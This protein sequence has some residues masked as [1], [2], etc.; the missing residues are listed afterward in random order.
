M[1]P[2][3]VV[4]STLATLPLLEDGR[5]TLLARVVGNALTTVIVRAE[6]L[7]VYRCTEM[8]SDASRLEPQALLDEIYPAVAYFQDTWEENVQQVR[9]A[10]LGKRADELS[11]ALKGELR[12]RVTPLVA[13]ATMEG[14]SAGLGQGLAGAPV[15]ALVGWMMNRGA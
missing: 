6:L 8:S 11:R 10:G 4:S 13:G 12:C 15:E 2:G 3:V 9:L 14:R 7:A 1:T 5:A